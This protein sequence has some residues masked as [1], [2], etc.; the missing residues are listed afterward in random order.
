M[1]MGFVD[2]VLFPPSS[3]ILSARVL[4]RQVV[5]RLIFLLLFW[6]IHKLFDAA[7]KLKS[8]GSLESDIVVAVM[9]HTQTV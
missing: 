7:A 4:T 3:L 1:R 5:W 9:G 8:T 2:N 6:V